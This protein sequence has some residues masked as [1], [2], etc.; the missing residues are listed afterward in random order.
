MQSQPLRKTHTH[1]PKNTSA[2]KL[3]EKGILLLLGWTLGNRYL[4]V[5]ST[6]PLESRKSA[7]DHRD[8]SKWPKQNC[9]SRSGALDIA[10]WATGNYSL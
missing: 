5:L 1:T 6:V 2:S 8:G 4:R 3:A 9:P 10:F 7:A